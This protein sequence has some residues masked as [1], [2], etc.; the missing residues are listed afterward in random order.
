MKR[1]VL[2]F[3]ADD[4]YIEKAIVTIASARQV[5]EWRDDI[6]LLLPKH[7]YNDI[8]IQRISN[9]LNIILKEIPERNFNSI[10]SEWDKHK[11]HSNYEYINSRRFIY[12]KFNIFDTYFKQWDIVFYL[13]A[14]SH[15]LGPLERIKKACNPINCL[16]AHSDA[17]PDFVWKLERQFCLELF[18]DEQK[19]KISKYKMDCDYFQS[20]ILIFDTSIIEMTT[21]DQLYTLSLEFPFA[22]RT[23]QAI[24]NLLFTCERNLWK[25]LPI[26]DTIGYLFDAH[27]RTGHT[28]AEYLILKWKYLEVYN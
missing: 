18:T 10:Y 4:P 26:K 23:D 20:I 12:N 19:D 16:Y 25:P 1:W 27:Q 11:E 5:G 7:L 3:I 24:M 9:M 21:V 28:A 13:D 2:I 17:Y 22:L 15:I 14:G 6:V 8:N